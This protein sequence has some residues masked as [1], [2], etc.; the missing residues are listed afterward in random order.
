MPYP[1]H[2]EALKR[3]FPGHSAAES[4]AEPTDRF[5][6]VTGGPGAG[7]STLIEALRTA[8]HPAVGEAGRAV[9]QQQAAI[10]G[11]ALPQR[12]PEL[13]AEVILSWELR[14]YQR[15]LAMPGVVFFDRGLPDVV[16]AFAMLG[17]PVPAHVRRAAETF[18]Y[19]RRAFLAP[20]WPEIFHRDAERWQDHAEA[21]RTHDAMVNA[22]TDLGYDLVTLPRADVPTRL[23]FVL[24]HAPGDQELPGGATSS[25]SNPSAS[26]R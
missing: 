3:M 22:Y 26:A 19:H 21:V 5:V 6:L 10:G 9:I 7:K 18:R 15:A 8:G 23:A 13:F 16:G 17:R 25:T 11:R 20:P 2:W 1:H 24:G 12:D 14:S 4:G